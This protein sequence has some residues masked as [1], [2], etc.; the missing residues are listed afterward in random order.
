M[1][2]AWIADVVYF[3][4]NV[5]GSNYGGGLDHAMITTRIVGTKPFF[6]QKSGNR[7]NVPAKQ[8][9]KNIKDGGGTKYK[10]YGLRT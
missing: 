2:D 5:R 9:K 4:W 3:D 10:V 7:H 8:V 1:G 6:S